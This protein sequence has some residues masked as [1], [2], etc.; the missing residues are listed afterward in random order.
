MTDRHK[1][2]QKQLRSLWRQRPDGKRTENDVIEFYGHMER[3][4]PH[5][6]NRRSGDPYQNL[7]SDLK[8]HIEERKKVL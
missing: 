1:V 3:T 4:F 7:Q 5:L 8:D 2:H 6:L